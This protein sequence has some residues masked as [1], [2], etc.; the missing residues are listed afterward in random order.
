MAAFRLDPS[1][2]NEVVETTSALQKHT[3]DNDI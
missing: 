1:A 2:F 3:I